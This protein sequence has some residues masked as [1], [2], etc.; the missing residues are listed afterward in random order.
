MSNLMKLPVNVIFVKDN[1]VKEHGGKLCEN[2]TWEGR[3]SLFSGKK[4]YTIEPHTVRTIMPYGTIIGVER[5][6]VDCVTS[7]GEQLRL[8]SSVDIIKMVVFWAKN[9]NS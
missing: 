7:E 6:S 3:R 8:V 4:V 5:A 9:L 2:L 1:N